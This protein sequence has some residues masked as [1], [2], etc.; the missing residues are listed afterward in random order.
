MFDEDKSGT[1]DKSELKKVM[2][3]LGVEATNDEVEKFMQTADK[4]GSGCIDFDEFMTFVVEKMHERNRN[5][6]VEIAFRLYDEEDKGKITLEN[7]KNVANEVKLDIPVEEL[8]DMI[9]VADRDGDGEVT[10]EDFKRIMRKMGYLE[11][12]V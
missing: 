1:I 8:E 11:D 4:D 9:R 2:L 10:L 3:T 5:E 7:L 12:H 6:D